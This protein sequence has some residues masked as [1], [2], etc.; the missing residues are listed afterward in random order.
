MFLASGQPR[1]HPHG[2]S[3]GRSSDLCVRRGHRSDCPDMPTPK[4]SQP[5][6]ETRV[7]KYS[8]GGKQ[9]SNITW[10][11]RNARIN[12]GHCTHRISHDHH[13]PVLQAYTTKESKPTPCCVVYVARLSTNDQVEQGYMLTRSTSAEYRTGRISPQLT[14]LADDEDV[15]HSARNVFH[16]FRVFLLSFL[17]S[18]S[19]LSFYILFLAFAVY[20]VGT[21]SVVQAPD[22]FHPFLTIRHPRIFA[23]E[24]IIH[25]CR[26][27]RRII[28]FYHIPVPVLLPA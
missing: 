20:P 26:V 3:L 1:S 19:V 25:M 18:L 10:H 13:Q 5:E 12:P 2:R 9:I 14:H 21:H 24:P 22:H 6:Q 8:Q 27:L 7:E 16:L 28:Y 23:H 4:N 11:R 15:I 17:L